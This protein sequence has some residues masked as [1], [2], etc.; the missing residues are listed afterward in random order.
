MC[1]LYYFFFYI[2]QI[3]CDVFVSHSGEEL[4]VSFYLFVVFFV[5]FTKFEVYHNYLLVFHHYTIRA[6]GL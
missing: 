1:V 6:T 3:T 4:H 5:C 2:P